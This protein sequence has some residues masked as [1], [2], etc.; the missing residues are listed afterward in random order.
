MCTIKP[1]CLKGC[2]G[3]KKRPKKQK[4]QNQGAEYASMKANDCTESCRFRINVP[5]SQDNFS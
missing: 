4:T 2:K 5:A 3:K 1:K